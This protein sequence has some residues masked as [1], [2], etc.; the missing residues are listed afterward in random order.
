M[1]DY[2][3]YVAAL[4]KNLALWTLFAADAGSDHNP[5]PLKLR[6]GIVQIAAFVRAETLRLQRSQSETGI[7]ALVEI[8]ANISAGLRMSRR[9]G[10]ES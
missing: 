1:Q 2:P 7:A 6:A 8:N 10:G 3:A 4:S 9:E 5:L